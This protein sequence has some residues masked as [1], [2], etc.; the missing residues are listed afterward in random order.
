LLLLHQVTK[1]LQQPSMVRVYESSYDTHTFLSSLGGLVGSQRPDVA[2]TIRQ[3]FTTVRNLASPASPLL[4]FHAG[5]RE[6]SPG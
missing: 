1:M 4:T 5:C 6:S 3:H 2:A